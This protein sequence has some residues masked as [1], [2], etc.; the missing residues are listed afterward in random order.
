[1]AKPVAKIIPTEDQEQIMIFRWARLQCRVYPELA[2]LYAVPNGGKR[3]MSTAKMLKATGVKAGVPDMCLPV[4]RG[5]YHG[6]YIELKR[7]R[8][9]KV[10]E[11]KKAWID[12]LREN[13][14]MAEVCYGCDDAIRRIKEYLA[15][16][17]APAV[18]LPDTDRMALQGDGDREL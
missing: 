14:Y 18:H 4:A 3:A 17:A 15:H 6:L 16:P 5:G 10:S 13:G 7:I 2:M 8:G 12:A 1:M 9:G 11:D